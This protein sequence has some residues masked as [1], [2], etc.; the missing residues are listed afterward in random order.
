MV[1]SI[2][3]LIIQVHLAYVQLS[4]NNKIEGEF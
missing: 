2:Y 1:T 4:L 3:E